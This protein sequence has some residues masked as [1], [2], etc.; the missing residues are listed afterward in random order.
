MGYDGSNFVYD[1]RRKELRGSKSWLMT[2][3]EEI[4]KTLSDLDKQLDGYKKSAE[5][6]KEILAAPELTPEL[7]ELKDKLTILQRID[8]KE[9]QGEKLKEQLEET[10]KNIQEVKKDIDKIKQAIGTRLNL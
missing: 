1:E 8:I 5:G 6:I 10:E 4:K 2:G 9:K 7:Q 3:E